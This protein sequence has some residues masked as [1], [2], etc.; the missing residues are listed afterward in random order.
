MDSK[1]ANDSDLI[2]DITS[3]TIPVLSPDTTTTVTHSLC[4]LVSDI[5]VI[6]G[7][8]DLPVTADLEDSYHALTI[9][10]SRVAH[11]RGVI[12]RTE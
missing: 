5:A 2:E 6:G 4:D 1:A 11:E 7:F 10:L 9:G 3:A 12:D 8:D